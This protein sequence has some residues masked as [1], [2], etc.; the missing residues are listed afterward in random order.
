MSDTRLS[1]VGD[2]LEI[3]SLKALWCEVI[4][5]V[6]FNP[7]AAAPRLSALFADDVKADYGP[8]GLFDGRDAVTRFLVEVSSKPAWLW[9]SLHSPRVEVSGDS[10]V[11]YWTMNGQ[12]K[13]DGSDQMLTSTNRCHDEFRRTPDGWRFSYIR[14]IHEA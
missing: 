3:Q 9:H 8:A 6:H 11:G 5:N 1:A 12:A 7:T 4:D 14:S 10:A 2:I 13:M